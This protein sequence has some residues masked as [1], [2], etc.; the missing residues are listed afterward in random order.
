MKHGKY[1]YFSDSYQLTIYKVN[2]FSKRLTEKKRK[3]TFSS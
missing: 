3:G 2:V 1:I